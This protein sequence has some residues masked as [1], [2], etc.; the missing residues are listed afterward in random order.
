MFRTIEVN[1]IKAIVFYYTLDDVELNILN[2]E[3]DI[4]RCNTCML[5]YDYKYYNAIIDELQC[6][7]CF[8]DYT[9]AN[10]N[11]SDEDIKRMNYNYKAM[12]DKLQPE[13]SII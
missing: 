3:F 4:V 10:V 5:L 13:E 6:K 11:H 9:Q 12:L 1:N 8:I 7:E 2:K